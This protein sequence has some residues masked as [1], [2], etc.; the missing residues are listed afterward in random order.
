MIYYSTNNLDLSSG[1]TNVTL[2]LSLIKEDYLTRT[3]MFLT[4]IYLLEDGLGI[5]TD[6]DLL[7]LI[8]DGRSELMFF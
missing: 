2:S 7:L 4:E 3:D 5:E 8:Y 6:R 1:T